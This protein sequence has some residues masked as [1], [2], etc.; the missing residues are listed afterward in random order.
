M[1]APSQAASSEASSLNKYSYTPSSATSLEPNPFEDLS[2]W[3]YTGS[4]VFNFSDGHWTVRK[5]T[6]VEYIKKKSLAPSIAPWLFTGTIL[7]TEAPDGTL[8]KD[9]ET[10]EEYIQKKA[11]GVKAARECGQKEKAEQKKAAREQAEVE[12]AEREKTKTWMAKEAKWEKEGRK[13]CHHAPLWGT[14][15]RLSEEAQ[16]KYYIENRADDY[17]SQDQLHGQKKHQRMLEAVYPGALVFKNGVDALVPGKGHPKLREERKRYKESGRTWTEDTSAL[18]GWYKWVNPSENKM[19]AGVAP[20]NRQIF[21][22]ERKAFNEQLQQEA[23]AMAAAAAED[24]KQSSKDKEARE[25]QDTQKRPSES[26]TSYPPTKRQKLGT[27][28]DDLPNHA[29]G[30]QESDRVPSSNVD[31]AMDE[32]NGLLARIDNA[33]QEAEAASYRPIAVDEP[34][35]VVDEHSNEPYVSTGEVIIRPEDTDVPPEGAGDTPNEIE[36]SSDRVEELAGDVMA[37]PPGCVAVPRYALY[38]PDHNFAP[39]VDPHEMMLIRDDDDDDEQEPLNPPAEPAV[40]ISSGESSDRHLTNSPEHVDETDYLE[41]TNSS[42]S[43]PT[44]S[45]LGS[46]NLRETGEKDAETL[47]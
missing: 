25:G 43:S 44:S 10:W 24:K 31:V 46:Q 35:Q 27:D 45:T 1:N 47:M 20:E 6:W 41:G 17:R 38:G 18:H 13:S 26:S 37:P 36:D 42:Y 33:E 34:P 30:S 11:A 21:D 16:T 39:G 22:E 23:L 8:T 9:H 32:F 29:D 14:T 7:T 3:F 4:R 28:A 12:I 5:E 19:L 40:P 2:Q 15:P